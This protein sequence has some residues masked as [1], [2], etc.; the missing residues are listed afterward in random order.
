M[1]LLKKK[2]ST[3]PKEKYY[4]RNEILRKKR[5]KSKDHKNN[6]L[7]DITTRTVYGVL[8]RYPYAY[9]KPRRFHIEE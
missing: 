5:G 1:I 2:K 3:P 4:E 8:R 7:Y 6:E 9:G